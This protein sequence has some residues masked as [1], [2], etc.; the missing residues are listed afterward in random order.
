MG[1]RN[2]Q[3]RDPASV[4]RPSD[5]IVDLLQRLI[6]T[7]HLTATSNW[8]DAVPLVHRYTAPNNVEMRQPAVKIGDAILVD[9]SYTMPHE[10]ASIMRAAEAKANMLNRVLRALFLRPEGA[11]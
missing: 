11:E 4:T 1:T 5:E 7:R 2:D 3:G 10:D 6:Q 8:A 9:V